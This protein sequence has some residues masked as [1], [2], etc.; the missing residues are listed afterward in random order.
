[1]LSNASLQSVL[2]KQNHLSLKLRNQ[3]H[4]SL[5][6]ILRTAGLIHRG[7]ITITATPPPSSVY[8]TLVIMHC[9]LV[10]PHTYATMISK[11]QTYS[12]VFWFAFYSFQREKVTRS[13]QR[14]KNIRS[15]VKQRFLPS[16]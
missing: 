15:S 1:M 8:Q 11:I 2:L 6:S 10:C 14:R 7:F 5:N 16:P 13:S 3:K 4:Y 9:Q 12:S